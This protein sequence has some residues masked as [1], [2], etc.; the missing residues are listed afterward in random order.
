MIQF[1]I[2][3]N[4]DIE[5]IYYLNKNL[6]D[7][8]EDVKSIDYE[9]VLKWVREKIEDNINLYKAI[10]YNGIKVG[11]FYLHEVDLKLEI[12]DLYIFDEYQNKGIGTF[13]LN[14]CIS[15]S[16][17]KNVSLFLYVFAKNT[18]A[19]SL[20]KRLGFEIIQNIKDTRYIMERNPSKA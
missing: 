13:V 10:F 20:Y 11:Y 8:Y 6:I 4:D 2:A 7:K 9:R 18:G 19:C 15:I 12:D 17:E 3:N 14:S 5:L 1:K 16:N